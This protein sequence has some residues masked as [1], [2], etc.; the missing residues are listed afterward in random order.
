MFIDAHCHL[1]DKAF[2][3]DRNEVIER[4]RLVGVEKMVVASSDLVDAEK[5]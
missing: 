4:A 3:K 1:T 5:W 2:D